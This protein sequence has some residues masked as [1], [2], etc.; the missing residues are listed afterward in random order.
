MDSVN[1]KV[2]GIYFIDAPNGIG[3]Q[4]QLWMG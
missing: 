1:T 4:P 2:G 3:K